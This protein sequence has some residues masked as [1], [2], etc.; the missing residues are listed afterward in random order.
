MT[1]PLDRSLSRR[2]F[3]TL[4]GTVVTGAAAGAL[5]PSWAQAAPSVAAPTLPDGLFTLGVASGDPL[6]DG[7]VLWTRLAPDPLAG[8]GMPAR[9]VPVQWQV[10]RDRRFRQ[11]VKNGTAR[12]EP[13]SGHSVH[14]D[15]RG[16]AS[17]AEYFYRFKAGSDL[18]VIGRTRT[19]PRMDSNGRVQFAFTSCQNWQDG[20]FT[21]YDHL[22]EEDFAFVAFLGDYIYESAPATSGYVRQ[23]E[24]TGEP[25]TLEQYRNRHAQ[26]RTDRSL[27]KAHAAL[28]WVVTWDDHELDNN[29]ADDVPQDPD[30]Q[31]PEA[32]RARRIAAFQAYYEHMPLRRSAAPVGPDMRLYRG[33]SFG[34]TV[35]LS[36]LDTRQ[37]RSDQPATLEEAESPGRSITG[38]AQERWL[39]H[40]LTGRSTW[41]VV[42]NQVMIAQNDRLAG[43]GATFDFDNW[44]GYRAQRRRLLSTL[45]EAGVDNTVFV[46]GDRHASWVCDLKPDFDDP[47][48]PVV[49]AE[50]TGTSI[51]S[52]GN[53]DTAAFHATY[54]PIKAESPHWK[55]I[56]NQR[57]YMACDATGTALTTELKVVS[58]V[59]QPGGTASTY[60][61]FVVTSGRP[62]VEVDY[63][64][65]RPAVVLRGRPE[66]GPAGPLPLDKGHGDTER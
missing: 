39:L 3:V 52:G 1:G 35:R 50:L 22:A 12:A 32:F 45:G 14:V 49:G 42:A 2:R 21:A 27:R 56:D 60:A 64:A 34:R 18:S 57:G 9:S 43:P 61:R 28:P 63:V 36:V 58:T 26:Y 65:P 53:P 48:S 38:T 10:A 17:D 41:N 13:E 59:T 29:W 40:R 46:T 62:G 7:V 19:A 33:L 25:I 20:Y 4:A 24:G 44:D 16:L 55:F 37:Y 30:A 51:T 31:T 8:G 47:E 54:D 66:M 6:P 11:I 23:H 15:V 5:V